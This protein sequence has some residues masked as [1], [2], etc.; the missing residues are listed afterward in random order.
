MIRE[1]I[2]IILS[3]KRGNIDILVK[4]LWVDRTFNPKMT[5]T[6]GPSLP[7][8]LINLIERKVWL[9]GF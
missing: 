4:S 8:L 7:F 6:S 9:M 3:M 5:A 1:E 2:A